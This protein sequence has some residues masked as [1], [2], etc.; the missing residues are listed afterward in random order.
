MKETPMMRQYVGFKR[1]YPDKLL[2]FRMG[3]FYE[4][5]GDDAKLASKILNITL[6]SRDKE[7]DPT[8]LAGFPH[9]A[10]E[11]YLPKVIN[12]G[13]SAVIVDQLEDP[14][15]AKGVVKRGVTRVVTPGTLDGDLADQKKNPYILAA[16]VA[17]KRLGI[18]LADIST[19]EFLLSEL[20]FTN[21]NFERVLNSY[22]PEELL[23][24][25][26]QKE[27]K[28]NNIP[29][30]LLDSSLIK[31]DNSVDIILEFYNA[32]SL[33]SIGLDGQGVSVVAASMVLSYIVD[34]Q[35]MEPRHIARPS[36][37]SFD[38]NMVLDRA[39]IRNLDLVA[40]SF[41][42]YSKDSLI[43]ILDETKTR[44]GKRL[45]Y[46]WVLNPLLQKS[47]IDQ[48]LDVVEQIFGSF[49]LMNDLRAMLSEISDVE[50]IVGKIGLNRAN[51]RDLNA[52]AYSLEKME[53]V[54]LLTSKNK[55][56]SKYL[57]LNKLFDT[58]DKS[59]LHSLI[60]LIQDCIHPTPPIT[61]TEGGIIRNGYDKEIDEIRSIAGDSKS[62]IKD[63]V[64][65]EKTRT[66]ISSLK[67]S[68]NKVFG[69]YIEVTKVHAQKVPDDYIRK[70]TLVNSE[71][72][73]TEDLK[74]KEEIILGSEERLAKLEYKIFQELRDGLL[75]YLENIKRAG[76][77]IA[78][79]D[80][81][82]S[83]A[84][85]SKNNLYVRPEI[86]EMGS[87][88]GVL[89]IKNGR[90][91]VIERLSEDQFVSNDT[92]VESSSAR[93]GIITG[94]NMSGKST[95]IRQVAIIVLMAQIGCF[96]PAD[97]VQLS[98][99]DRIFSRVGAAD[100]LAQGRSTFMVEMEEA[101]NILNNATE[102]S[103]VILDEV[104]RGT[105]TYDGVSIAWSLA[106]Y[107]V[108][109]IKARTLF[110]T[111]YHELLELA[112]DHPNFVKN[113]NV[114]V[115]EDPENDQVIFLRK[116][117][118]G[119]TSRS[120]GIYVAKMAGLP[121]EVTER[122]SQILENF[123]NQ[124]GEIV[125]LSSSRKEMDEVKEMLQ[126]SMFDPKDSEIGKALKDADVENM[127]P[128]EA[129]QFLVD[130]KNRLK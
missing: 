29:V 104:G 48:R 83:F 86:Y 40:N 127:T 19:G 64:E 103:L 15:L 58:K 116:I 126:I 96:V 23:L 125:H 18:A 53:A 84:F 35:K 121:V 56:L 41:T 111:H 55:T 59:S 117:I 71:R 5:F 90:H 8:P 13:Y 9:H 36:V 115:E 63:F 72:Y 38:G 76:N 69:Y 50:R 1:Q 7:S 101:A 65:K 46:S 98:I 45:L 97:Q 79:L 100:N 39:T 44:M 66:G 2:L 95:F 30:Q 31:G 68:F 92:Y 85:I 12:A 3:D 34:T 47:Q 26:D 16:F 75:K 130:L 10:L 52:L 123:K 17:K 109:K 61:I 119:G 57:D 37:V 67:I 14:K 73:I 107:L 78:K 33:D 89:K 106:E 77:Q 110:A 28:A 21:E 108:E 11:Q 91:P 118:E 51:A 114:H 32:K 105:S 128:I 80:L 60:I 82:T 102:N 42:G 4:T 87:K 43:E 49:E 94:P 112:S 124:R 62:W 122:A 99:V 22:D 93:M 81:L 88:G 70:Q 129:F 24:I 54:A 25:S 20:P 74:K 113:Y 27:I 120:Y 6:T